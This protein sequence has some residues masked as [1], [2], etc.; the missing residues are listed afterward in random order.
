MVLKSNTRE[1]VRNRQIHPRTWLRN[2]LQLKDFPENTPFDPEITCSALPRS[3]RRHIVTGMNPLAYGLKAA[4]SGFATGGEPQILVSQ[5]EEEELMRYN[6]TLFRQYGMLAS[7]GVLALSAAL[8]LTAPANAQQL[9]SFNAPKAGAGAGQGTSAIGINLKGTITGTVKDSYNV[10]RGFVGTLKRGFRTFEAPDADANVGGTYPVAINEFDV[11]TGYSV[12]GNSVAHGFVRTPDGTITIFDMPNDAEPG[13]TY[14]AGINNLAAVVGVYLDANYTAHGFVRA[15]EGKITTFD[16][17]AG[18]SG[19]WQGTWPYNINDFGVIVGATTYPDS[20]SHGLLRTLNGSYH[21]F[22][23][24]SE[25][26]W[27]SAYINDL[28]VIVGSYAQAPDTDLVAYRRTAD[29]KMTVLQTP[30]EGVTTD[31]EFEGTYVSAVN[32]LGATTGQ[33]LNNDAELSAFV[34]DPEGKVPVFGYKDQAAVPGSYTGSAGLA[35][36]AAG[37]VVG[38]WND[39]NFATHGL[40]RLPK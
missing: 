19:P 36:N 28:G 23:F 22:E 1:S 6:R 12:D 26:N 16:D 34:R 13:G 33:V 5:Y 21:D 40:V 31:Y 18:G 37:V 39:R 2:A 20:S 29:G 30:G 38:Y 11:I 25:T 4:S 10:T 15:A 14:P 9:I 35:I 7:F 17:P 3:G 32:I 8:A 24:P 27:S